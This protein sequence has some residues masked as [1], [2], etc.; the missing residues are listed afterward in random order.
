MTTHKCGSINLILGCMF[1]GKT[2]ELQRE[3]HEWESIGK[4]PLC[5]NSIADN[6]DSS[7]NNMC[8]HNGK[9]VECIKVTNLAEVTQELLDASEIILINEG[10]FFSDLIE[11]CK[12]WCEQQGKYIIVCGLDGDFK[13]RPFGEILNLI[14]LADSVKKLTAYCKKCS[15]GTKALFSQ[16]TT[17]ENETIIIGGA[18]S[19]RALC[20]KCYVEEC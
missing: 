8:T 13:R 2:T 19:Y 11:Y 12:K 3:Y 5:I 15:D 9:S 1:S 7:F 14:P 20:R 18:S 16:R 10:Q 17:T 6:R 4:N